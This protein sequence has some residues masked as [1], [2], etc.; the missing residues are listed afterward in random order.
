LNNLIEIKQHYAVKCTLSANK[1]FPFTFI[2]ALC[3]VRK[4]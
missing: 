1:T 3:R 2:Y 4:M